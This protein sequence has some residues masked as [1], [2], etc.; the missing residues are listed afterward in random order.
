MGWFPPMLSLL[1][2]NK[3]P[4]ANRDDTAAGSS[5]PFLAIPP[6]TKPP[7]EGETPVYTQKTALTKFAHSPWAHTS[8]VYTIQDTC[9]LHLPFTAL[10]HFQQLKEKCAGSSVFLFSHNVACPGFISSLYYL[11]FIIFPYFLVLRNYILGHQTVKQGL[12]LKA[13]IISFSI[14]SSNTSSGFRLTFFCS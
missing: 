10:P 1:K 5:T 12:L 2:G 14:A 13:F 9:P 7:Q 8:P 4:F 6:G 11:P 3:L